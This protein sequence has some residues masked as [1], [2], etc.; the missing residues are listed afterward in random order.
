MTKVSPDADSHANW[1]A[2]KFRTL[3]ASS[4][5]VL[6]SKVGRAKSLKSRCKSKGRTGITTYVIEDQPMS[7]II[8]SFDPRISFN[9]VLS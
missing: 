5:V 4:E 3:D 6:Y 8:L 1:G 2:W 7:S 9:S